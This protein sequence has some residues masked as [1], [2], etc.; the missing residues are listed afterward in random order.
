MILGMGTDLVLVD[1]LRLRM[2]RTSGFRDAVFSPEEIACCERRS[3]PYP[4]FAARFAA[5]EALMKALGTGWSG[6]VAFTDISVEHE[7]QLDSAVDIPPYTLRP[8]VRLQ[9]DVAQRLGCTGNRIHLSL[10]H[11]GNLAMAFVVIESE[12]APGLTCA[13]KLG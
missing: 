11:T 9:G 10:T 7:P 1:D 8:R 3:N 2:Q 4:C 13:G 12:P 5:K 6:G